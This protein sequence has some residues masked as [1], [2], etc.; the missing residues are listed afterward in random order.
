VDSTN[1]HNSVSGTKHM[2]GMGAVCSLLSWP[3]QILCDMLKWYLLVL[4][5]SHGDELTNKLHGAES[6]LR[7]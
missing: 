1:L 6:L 2:V 4:L 3:I 7:S 5:M